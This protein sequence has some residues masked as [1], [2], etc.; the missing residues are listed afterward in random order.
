[1]KKRLRLIIVPFA[2][3]FLILIVLSLLLFSRLANITGYSAQADRSKQIVE[4]LYNLESIVKDL[5]R[6][7]RGYLLT[8]DTLY[9]NG[10]ERRFRA[11]QTSLTSLQSMCAE[12]R[13]Q[14]KQLVVL[15]SSLAMR[16][17]HL[18]QSI[19]YA[20]TTS[21][22]DPGT[23]YYQGRRYMQESLSAITS[24]RQHEAS[25][26]ESQNRNKYAYQTSTL[27]YIKWLAVILFAITIFLFVLM[28][29][30]L[31]DRLTYQ[32]ELQENLIALKRTHAELEQIAFAA[33]HDLQEP[34]RKIQVLSNRLELL[35]KDGMSSDTQD[36]ITRISQAASRMHHLIEDMVNLT[37][38][39]KENDV[40]KELNL[41]VIVRNVQQEL[42]ATLQKNNTT[43]EAG[44][45]AMIYGYQKQIHI[46]FKSL[47]DNASKFSAT[48]KAPLMTIKGEYVT[49][50]ELMEISK[51]LQ[52]KHYYRI[53]IADN[54]IGFD[55]RFTDKMFKIF[56][57]L[58]NQETYDGKGIGLALCQRIMTNHNGYIIANGHVGAGATFKIF[59]PVA[60][61][62]I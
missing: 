39:T 21:A 61:T 6:A 27:N 18:R 59:F 15:K 37:S 13:V 16:V 43:I 54:G 53:T 62:D 9:S 12:D 33:S 17:F 8:R 52:E 57:R 49:G 44:T 25:H 55:N 31:R 51:K 3:S 58:H 36:T 38:L 7:E 30:A 35:K 60:E 32:H 56:Q 47:I 42:A 45:L 22:K 5:D 2:T 11:M 1:M 50:E 46:L 20:D 48:G 19:A 4:E 26:L 14:Q 23:A 28:I 41:D 24:L 40:R 29:K 10:F 34:L